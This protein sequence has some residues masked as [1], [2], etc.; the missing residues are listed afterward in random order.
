M[1]NNWQNI[2]GVKSIRVILLI[3]LIIFVSSCIASQATTKNTE[4]SQVAIVNY[5]AAQQNPD[6]NDEEKIKITIDTYFTLRYEGQKSITEQDF[7]SLV[8][9]DTLDWVKKE[10]DKREIELYIACMFDLGYQ[11]YKFDLD[12]TSIEIKKDKAEVLL[13]ESHQVV[14]N[15]IAPQVSEMS[16]LSHQITLHNKNGVWVIYQ[17]EYKDENTQLIA[18]STKEEIKKQVD[19]NYS[20]NGESNLGAPETEKCQN[21]IH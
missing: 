16:G 2:I 7:S 19:E 14:F 4:T 3:P 13:T 9:D 21:I 5:L 8:E 15:A 1:K 10:R 6:L 17:D 11:S 12:Y 18:S 20:A